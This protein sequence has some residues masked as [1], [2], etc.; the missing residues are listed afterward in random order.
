MKKSLSISGVNEPGESSLFK[1]QNGESRPSLENGS[2]MDG[3]TGEA[4]HSSECLTGTGITISTL[5]PE[6]IVEKIVRKVG[7]YAQEDSK[8]QN[9]V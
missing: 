7:F 5:C 8:Q 1:R 6:L 3:P 2:G 9:E 4:P